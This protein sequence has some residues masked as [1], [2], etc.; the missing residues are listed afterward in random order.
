MK[1]LFSI[2]KFDFSVPMTSYEFI[3]I[4][5]SAV[6]II[7]PIFQAIWKKWIVRAKLKYYP[8]GRAYLYCNKSGSYISI[9]GVFEA[10]RKPITVK[11]VAVSIERVKDSRKLNLQWS[12][13]N[14]PV[15][16]SIAGNFASSS[17]I[18][19]PFRIEA[20]SVMCAFTE[21]ADA[22]NS[23][24]K[25]I[26]PAFDKLTQKMMQISS[27][28]QDYNVVKQAIMNTPE[29]LEAKSALE[30][31][32]YWEIGK[33]N[34]V[35]TAQYSDK[36]VTFNHGFEVDKDEYDKLQANLEEV[37][38]SCVKSA[39]RVPFAMQSVSVEFE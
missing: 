20:D 11:K 37:L 16:Q 3:A 1:E 26:V 18:A 33:Y 9:E 39:Y 6:A 2:P 17:E 14:S 22:Y 30:K 23:A 8:T 28:T 12:V 29:Y 7:I 19:H 24:G 32:Y 34:V 38:I 36:I 21:F 5:L 31:E 13:F 35:I 4:I 15:N 25:K 10:L 27:S